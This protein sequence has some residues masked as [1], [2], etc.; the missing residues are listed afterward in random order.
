MQKIWTRCC[1][2]PPGSCP[3]NGSMPWVEGSHYPVWKH[4]SVLRDF[5]PT[6]FSVKQ[7]ADPLTDPAAV[8]LDTNICT[9]R[10]VHNACTTLSDGP[11]IIPHWSSWSRSCNLFPRVSLLIWSD[12][13]VPTRMFANRFSLSEISDVSDTEGVERDRSTFQFSWKSLMN[14][15]AVGMLKILTLLNSSVYSNCYPAIIYEHQSKTPGIDIS[16]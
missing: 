4:N 6:V 5:R 8:V 10:N 14:E 12:V 3:C 2:T 7:P 11:K 13:N 9:G 15:T 1:S 16:L